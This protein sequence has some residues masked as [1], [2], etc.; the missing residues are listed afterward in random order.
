M[1]LRKEAGLS[2]DNPPGKRQAGELPTWAMI[3]GSRLSIW[4]RKNIKIVQM[5]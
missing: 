1:I 3:S 5:G 4:V 2:F